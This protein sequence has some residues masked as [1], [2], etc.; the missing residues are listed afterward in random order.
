MRG[1]H[2]RSALR[3][4]AEGS[5]ATTC[6]ARRHSRGRAKSQS[7]TPLWSGPPDHTDDLP[8]V[9]IYDGC[10]TRFEPGPG[11]S[12]WVLEVAHG[13]EPAF[14]DAH[15][16]Q[17]ELVHTRQLQQVRLGHRGPHLSVTVEN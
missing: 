11:L 7:P 10:H 3:N 13:A 15:Y 16:P 9:Q 17:A 1:S 5:I 2:I 4:A 12:R 14:I 6:T 8:G